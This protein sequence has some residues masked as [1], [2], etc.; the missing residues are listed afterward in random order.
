M[1]RMC[2][3]CI[4]GT[5]VSSSPD[6]KLKIGELIEISPVANCETAYHELLPLGDGYCEYG[7]MEPHV[8][9]YEVLDAEEVSEGIKV[10]KLGRRIAAS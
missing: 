2:R 8:G 9:D 1:I 5:M 4:L 6:H 7:E 3:R 10:Y